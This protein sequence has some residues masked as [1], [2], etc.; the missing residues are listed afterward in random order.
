MFSA[1]IA[2]EGCSRCLCSSCSSVRCSLSDFPA[3]RRWL[4]KSEELFC[5]EEE[6]EVAATAAAEE[7]GAEGEGR[8]EEA[9]AEGCIVTAETKKLNN[10]MLF[11][12]SLRN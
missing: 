7:E 12:N 6:G 11:K 10:K 3:W 9:E 8:E 5:E 4:A 1:D 2:G